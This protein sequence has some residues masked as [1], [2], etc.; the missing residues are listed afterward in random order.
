MMDRKSRGETALVLADDANS[1]RDAERRPLEGLKKVALCERKLK[2][3]L[4][5]YFLSVS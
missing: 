5:S 1:T 2:C 3:V 4:F